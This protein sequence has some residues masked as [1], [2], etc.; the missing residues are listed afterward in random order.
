MIIHVFRSGLMMF[1][2]EVHI[3]GGVPLPGVPPKDVPYVKQTI[4]VNYYICTGGQNCDLIFPG[5]MMIY[6]VFNLLACVLAEKT[7]HGAFLCK[8]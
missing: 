3:C 4:V 8:P 6:S 7:S 5:V 1:T 2:Q